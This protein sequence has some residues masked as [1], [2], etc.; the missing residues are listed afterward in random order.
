ML[1]EVMVEVLEEAVHVV[2]MV[3]LILVMGVL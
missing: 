3:L 2:V 1:Q